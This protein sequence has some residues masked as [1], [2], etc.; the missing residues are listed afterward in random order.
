[1]SIHDSRNPIRKM[2]QYAHLSTPDPEYAA[3]KASLQMQPDLP[4]MRAA[5]VQM[6]AARPAP[7][8]PAGMDIFQSWGSK[9]ITGVL[10]RSRLSRRGPSGK[11]RGG[12]NY[13]KVLCA[14]ASCERVISA[15]GLVSWRWCV[16]LT[17]V[18][19]FPCLESE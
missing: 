12:R 4:T 18:D 16:Q 17:N 6:R 14:Y 8:L 2:S 19:G 3:L 10:P 9:N 15:I 1:M 13:S 7:S 11:R 5:G